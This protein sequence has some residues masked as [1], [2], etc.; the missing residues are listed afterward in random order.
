MIA[1]DGTEFSACVTWQSS[2]ASWVDIAP[3]HALAHSEVRG[4]R[5]LAACGVT[6]RHHRGHLGGG[7]RRTHC[8]GSRGRG[9]VLNLRAGDEAGLNHE[10]DE[11]GNPFLVVPHA[12]IVCRGDQLNLV[13]KGVQRPL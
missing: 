8:G 3:A 4:C 13:T 6:L 11:R 12:Q 5:D 1:V 10:L 9:S 7:E 2:M